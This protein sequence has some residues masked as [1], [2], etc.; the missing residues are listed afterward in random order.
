MRLIG[1]YTI[2][3]TSAPAASDEVV[4]G[5]GIGVVSTDAAGAGSSAMPDPLGEPEY[6]WL[7]WKAHPLFFAGTDPEGAGQNYSLRQSFDVKSMRKLKPRESLVLVLQYLDVAG[8][9]P[10]TI[11]HGH[12]RVLLAIG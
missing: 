10:I 6:P 4:I 2:A 11:A 9:V 12:T 7:Y 3:A 1:E 5:V 8:T